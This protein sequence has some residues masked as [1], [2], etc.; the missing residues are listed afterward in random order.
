MLLHEAFYQVTF[1]NLGIVK[2]QKNDCLRKALMELVEKLDEEFRRPPWRPFP[3]HL[4]GSEMQCPKES[5]T[6]S[7]G[8]ARHFGLFPLPKPAALHIG[9]IGP[10]RLIGK[11]NFDT[12]ILSQLLDRLDD[13][14]HPLFFCSALGAWWGRVLAKRL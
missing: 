13:L 6:L 2:D 12:L 11:Q 9:F 8:R 1:V 5:G 3:I 10:M 7:P 4:L 14:C